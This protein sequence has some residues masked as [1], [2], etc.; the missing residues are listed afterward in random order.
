ME[1]KKK[2]DLDKMCRW[3]E[4]AHCLQD[5]D[6]MLCDK[7]GIVQADY[8]CRNFRYDPLKRIPAQSKLISPLEFVPLED[9]EQEE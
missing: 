4:S 5:E 9:T 6:T 2:A 8:V 3:C 1:K 7:K